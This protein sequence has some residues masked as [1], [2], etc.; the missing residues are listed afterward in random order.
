LKPSGAG[1][2]KALCPFHHE[3]TPSFTV[4]RDRQ[5][6][7]C[8]GCQKHGDAITFLSEHDGM[9]FVE[10]IQKLA[11]RA[12]VRLPALTER[13]SKEDYQRARAFELCNFAAGFFVD[14]LANPLKGGQGRQYL[15]TRKIKADT[16]KKFR[17]GYVPEEWSELADAARTAG[18]KDAILTLSGLVKRG[19]GGRI[20]DFFRN[21]LMFPIHDVA[22][23]VVAFG[24]RDLG[25]GPAKYINSPESPVYKKGRVLYGLYEARDAMRRAKRAVL[26]EGYFDLLRC[27]DAGIENVVATC[28]TALTPDQAKLIR[29][30]VPEVT[31]V[32]DGDAA[33]IRAALRGIAILAGVDLRVSGL[34]LPEGLDPDDYIKEH[35]ADAFRALVDEAVDF[36]TF[37]IRANAERLDTIEG[38]TDVARDIFG[39][40]AGMTDRMRREEYLKRV[41]RE[42]HID[43][44]LCRDEFHKF[45]SRPKSR[46]APKAAPDEHSGTVLHE[47][48]D[49]I[50]SLLHNGPLLDEARTALAGVAAKPGPMP[51][52][53]KALFESSGPEVAQQLQSEAAQ[54]LYAAAVNCG[55]ED[56]PDNAQVLVTEHVTR[57]KKSALLA[58]DARVLEAIREAEQAQ[59]ENRIAE[60]MTKKGDLRKQIEAVGAA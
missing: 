1:R 46:P 22:G 27:F 7:Y 38:R 56:M 54:A 15:K 53:L 35:G 32:F 12:G 42:L 33:G 59:D 5:M 57:F 36:V 43:E 50:A 41:A 20:Y 45:A 14:S 25:D 9:P 16:V 8:F 37:Y 28:G 10:A 23:H 51:E 40:L 4:N 48:R 49:L 19:D 39:V 18:F 21:R 24:G 60:L 52:V 47:E 58:E 55:P 26:V 17:L 29:R 2:F 11:E 13:D 3:K 44:F 31:V 30:Y 34:I 6:Y